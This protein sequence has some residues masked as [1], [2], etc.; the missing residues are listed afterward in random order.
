ME[1]IHTLPIAFKHHDVGAIFSQQNVG[2]VGQPLVD[3]EPV[4]D[5]SR[6]IRVAQSLGQENF[7][8][9]QFGTRRTRKPVPPLSAAPT[10]TWRSEPLT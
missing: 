7:R 1:V 6:A 3:V 4:L 10:V 2:R 5:H 8:V 9:H